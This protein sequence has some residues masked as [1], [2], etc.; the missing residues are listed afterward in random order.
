[1]DRCERLI[2][3]AAELEDGGPG[4]RFEVD[5]GGETVPAFAVRYHG[6]VYAYLNRC[7]HL[8]VE[9]DWLPGQFFDCA[10]EYLVCATHGACFRPEDGFCFAGPCRGASLESLR[11]ALRDGNI[12]VFIQLGIQHE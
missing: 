10:H 3:A 11:V 4:L 2:G 5:S 6:R 7:A 8:G 9:L 12:F 1:M